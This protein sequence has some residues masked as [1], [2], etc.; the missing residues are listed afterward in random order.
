MKSKLIFLFAAT[1][2]FAQT[3]PLMAGCCWDAKHNTTQEEAAEVVLEN[4]EETA[5]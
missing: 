3:A 2:L 4:V 1:L 5:K